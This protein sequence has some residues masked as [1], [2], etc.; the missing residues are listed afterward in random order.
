MDKTHSCPLCRIYE[1]R[2][3]FTRVYYEDDFCIILDCKTCMIPMVVIKEHIQ[4]PSLTK[5]LALQEHFKRVVR[6]YKLRPGYYD[7]FPRT[8]KDHFHIH[9]RS[10][11]SN[12]N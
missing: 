8:V 11:I 1:K 3:I 4:Y 10:L 5:R 7:S 6:E 12:P 9:Y 2:E